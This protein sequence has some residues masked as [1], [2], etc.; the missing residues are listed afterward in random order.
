MEFFDLIRINGSIFSENSKYKTHNDRRLSGSNTHDKQGDHLPNSRIGSKK[1][2]KR[3][4]IY[5][6]TVSANPYSSFCILVN[7]PHVIKT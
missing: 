7:Y 2:V 4:K 5:S 3:H 1:T 6:G